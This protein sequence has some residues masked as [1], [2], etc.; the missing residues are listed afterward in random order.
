MEDAKLCTSKLPQVQNI[1]LQIVSISVTATNGEYI[2]TYALLDTGN[3]CTL[4]RSNLAKR[5]SLRKKTNIANISN[6][7]YSGA[8]INVDEVKFYVIDEE[9]TSSFHI[10]KALTI[11]K[12]RFNMPAQFLPL[13][14]Q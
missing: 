5:S 10:N 2:S 7:K 13:H 9:N 1:Y 8:V 11:K 12:E 6:I 4:I 14:F 3:E